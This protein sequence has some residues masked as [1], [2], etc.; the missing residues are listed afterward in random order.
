[1]S[2]PYSP[3]RI[4]EALYN[5]AQHLRLRRRNPWNWLVQTASLAL[6]PLGLLAHNVPLLALCVIGMACGFFELPLP[7]MAQSGLKWLVPYLEKAIGWENAW[8]A[9]PLDARKKRQILLWTL[10]LAAASWFLWDQDLAPIGLA[11]G[12]LYLLHVRRENIKMGIKP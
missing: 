5:L 6:L 1:M 9:R 2:Q 3:Q 12:T 10:G 4:R 11:I 7:P 8:L